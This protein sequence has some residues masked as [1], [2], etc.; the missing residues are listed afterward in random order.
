[1]NSATGGNVI[2]HFKGDTSNLDKGISNATSGM[3][4]MTKSILAA[5]GITKALSAGFNMI[6]NSMD[7]AITRYDTMNNFPKVMKNLGVATQDAED[8]ISTMSE[9]LVGLPT[10]LDQGAMAVQRFTS[11]N[12]DVKKSTDIF[13]AVNNAILAGGASA[14]I[15]ATALEQLS[16]AYAKGKPDMMEWRTLMTA[17]PAQLN[18]V[19]KAMG[20]VKSADLG[21][22]IRADG[23]EAEFQRMI[24][25]IVK[26]NKT[27]ID[28]F[29]SL[30]EQAKSATNGISTGLVNMKSR[31]AT[32]VA[33]M[34]SA[35]NTG[36]KEN[37]LG[38]IAPTLEKIGSTVRDFLVS[39]APYITQVFNFILKNLPP[40]VNFIGKV[41][42]YL[43]P[44]IA[45]IIAFRVYLKALQIV[46]TITMAFQLFNMVLLAN[47]IGLII[48][49][50]TLLIVGFVLLWKKCEWFRNFWINL[51]NGI[52]TMVSNFITWFLSIPEQIK[53]FVDNVITFIQNIP[54]F[55]GYVIGF[56]IT[57]LY[58]FI[59]ETIPN[60]IN[61]VITWFQKL[62]GRIWET[63]SLALEKVKQWT[64]DMYN[65]LKVAIPNLI[66]SIIKWFQELPGKML[67]IGQDMIK[68]LVEGI[69]GAKKW[70]KQQVEDFAKGMLDGMKDA[71][72]IRS[73][74]KE[75]AIIGRY[76]VLGYAEG[77]ENM[78]SQLEDAV[79][80]TFSLS[81]QFANSSALHYS[82]N[83]VVNNNVNMET[84]PL[85]QTVARIKTF[86]NGSKNDYNYGIG[87]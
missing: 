64:I 76:S 75:F 82:P 58:L 86:A 8:S 52:K 18:Q 71:L 77:L 42:P 13:L 33:E 9:A 83:V 21:E 43:T 23:G 66:S 47:P 53:T 3:K 48:A 4:G 25:T 62:P 60:F 44:I 2:F 6:T 30:E 1:M 37:G 80:D 84:D 27:G 56:V 85:G 20:Y 14:D 35:V 15:Q 65:K 78:K 36:L 29:A 79:Y 24:E 72:G 46:R 81:P 49:G 50:I 28:G 17:M 51:W 39:L 68:G 74:S 32:G 10:T 12:G 54:Y 11:A 45:A 67:K 31:I 40:I 26:L 87:V 55:V 22:A 41:L 61:G 63:L 34:I 69:K 16:Q 57:K 70:A 19:A 7:S 59:T 73:P 5:T 38:G